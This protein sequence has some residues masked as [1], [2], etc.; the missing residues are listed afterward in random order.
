MFTAEPIMKSKSRREIAN[1]FLVLI[2]PINPIYSI[3]YQP[4]SVNKPID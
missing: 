1:R 4:G 3:N 2:N